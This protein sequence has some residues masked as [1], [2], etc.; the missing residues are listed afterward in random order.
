MLIAGGLFFLGFLLVESRVK[1]PLINLGMFKRKDLTLA[2]VVN[3][4]IGY[5]LFIGLVS[6]PILV[7]IRQE[8]LESLREAALQVGL[9]LST[10]TVPMALAAV[11]G[12]WLS[13]RIGIRNTVVLGVLLSLLGFLAI[14]SSWQIDTSD[15]VVALQMATVG[16]GIGLTF[17]PISAAII[18][19]ATESERG[20]ASALVIILRLIGMTISVSSLTTYGLFRVNQLAILAQQNT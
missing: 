2:S 6:V 12:G 17:S 20:V 11:P 10:L 5:A 14:W 1:D 15:S 4:L 18:N 13:D 19:S 16:I 8:S 7:N 3:I 9:L